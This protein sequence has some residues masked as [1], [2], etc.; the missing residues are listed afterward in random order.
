MLSEFVHETGLSRPVLFLLREIAAG[1]EEGS[2]TASLRPGAPYSTRDPHLPWLAEAARRGYALPVAG[3]RWRIMA[4]GWQLV[5]ELEARLDDFVAGL[6]PLPPDQLVAIAELLDSIASGL[7]ATAGG[8]AGRLASGRRL[9]EHRQR[10]EPMVRLERAIRELW[11]AR[12]DAH[13]G[14]WRGAWFNGPSIDLLTR[15]WQGDVETLPG[16]RELVAETHEAATVVELVDELIEQGYVERRGEVVRPTRAGYV[17][18]E[19]IEAETDRLYF[20][21]WPELPDSEVAWLHGRLRDAIDALA[22]PPG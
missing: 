13:I 3:D 4:A 22:P 5:G 9:T 11:L 19:T 18:R 21:Q 2:A 6:R 20:M 7:D 17:I 16:L 15:L 8:A 1:P 12:D 10:D 14:A